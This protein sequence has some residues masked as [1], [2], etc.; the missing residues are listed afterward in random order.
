MLRS[1]RLA[2]TLVLLCVM[3]FAP[4][5]TAS[6]AWDG[7]AE[8]NL[9][10]TGAVTE[11]P[12]LAFS[13]DGSTAVVA[14][15]RAGRVEVA[16]G[17]V[18]GGTATWSAPTGI[19][20][21][22]GHAYGAVVAI[23]S[24]GSKVVASWLRNDGSHFRVQAVTGTITGGVASWGIPID[25]S[26]SGRNAEVPS[27]ALSADGTRAI[28][29]WRRFAGTYWVPQASRLTITGGVANWSA[30][31][32]FSVAN[33]SSYQPQAAVARNGSGGG[34][35]W[36]FDSWPGIVQGAFVTTS[37]FTPFTSDTTAST[38]VDYALFPRLAI[39]SDMAMM[40]W[41]EET[42]GGNHVIKSA[43]ALLA[44]NP[45]T[46]S[47]PSVVSGTG[48]P[49]DSAVTDLSA[50]GSVALAT[51]HR[52]SGVNV[53]AEAAVATVVN[54]AATWQV[55]TGLSAPGQP[56]SY[57]DTD[58]AGNGEA[59]IAVWQRADASSK[60]RVQFSRATITGGAAQWSTP[61][62]ISVAGKDS[63]EPVVGMSDDAS[64]AIAVWLTEETPGT[65]VVTSRVLVDRPAGP[66]AFP[67]FSLW[68]VSMDPAEGECVD[69][70]SSHGD[71]WTSVF[72]GYRYLPGSDDCE[73]DG[74]DF[75]G[76]A[77]V[78]DPDTPLT[79]PL[80]VDPTDGKKR[81][82]VAANHSLVAVWTPVD[83]ELENLAGTAP[84][85]FVGGVDRRTREGGGVVDGF[86]IPPGTPFGSWMLQ[87]R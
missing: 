35:A 86:Y 48:Q 37:A 87:R 66:S 4:S 62:D 63:K 47:T 41:T 36:H 61:V 71:V 27:V 81:W 67:N 31:T 21:P 55:P 78:D 83:D 29:A 79:L 68:T 82:F 6:A 77:D 74:F 57:L 1:V 25:L 76:W 13:G 34:V 33:R 24:D 3:G 18:Q 39:E 40:T 10:V 64:V 75:N 58:L 43:S 60:I 32:T 23:S 14:W 12:A 73:R 56:A 59:A 50:N 19:S 22:G 72:I 9:S 42:G 69:G 46:W 85:S 15:D 17:S 44:S 7:D 80:L 54:G 2:V 11:R 49:A 16:V 53:I 84:G 52:G 45:L 30:S 70:T 8:Q 5:S 26:D 38:G 20:D 51:W 28:V 65:W